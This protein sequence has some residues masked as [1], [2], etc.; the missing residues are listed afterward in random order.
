MYEK[1]SKSRQVA[2]SMGGLGWQITN[3][4]VVSVGVYYYLP[5]DGS[6]L[7]TQ[8]SSKLFLGV[9]TAYGLARLIGGVVDSLADPFVGHLSDRSHSRFGRRRAFMIYGS[10]PM[11]LASASIF[12]PPGVPGS[13][14]SFVF[15]S[16]MLATYYVFFTVYV[17]PYL[18]LI[19][20]IAR[21][22]QERIEFT[23]I[24]ALVFGPAIMAYS[25]IWLKGVAFAQDAGL[26]TE[27]ALRWVVAISAIVAFGLC[28]VPIFAVDERRYTASAPTTMPWRQAFGTTL[29]NRTFAIF[30][31]AQALLIMGSTMM[32]PSGPYIAQVLLG[33]DLSF[34]ANL[35][36]V[37]FP[38]ISIGFVFVDRVV[39]RYGTKRTLVSS[40]VLLGLSLLPMIFVR[41]DV[42][43][44]PNDALN[45]TIVITSLAVSGLPIASLM[46]LP[47]VML[48]QLI[49]L[50]EVETG[51]NRSA[52]Y[53]GVQGLLTKWVYAAAA[54]TLSFLFVKFG[55]SVDEPWG[56]ILL[57]PIGG[58]FCL[59]SAFIYA[60][61]PEKRVLE[62]VRLMEQRAAAK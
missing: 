5:P 28:L 3:T 33:R 13:T 20:E 1:M 11:A 22:E 17:G 34:A 45:L 54:A 38:S 48:A 19:P 6:G 51:A 18:A 56:V 30:L 53:F 62:D 39:A 58:A 24:R 29:R 10:L 36:L 60:F 9:L 40:V 14:T 21:S 57:G 55:N 25:F 8:L 42:P 52:M 4:L 16:V 47:M 50:D 59:L 2:Y 7:E 15:L 46:I 32:G 49:D 43:G 23:R 44:G 61:Y 41:P 26:D 12:W 35:G 27:T 31:F 37:M